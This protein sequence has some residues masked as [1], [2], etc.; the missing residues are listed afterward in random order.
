MNYS[1]KGYCKN[2]KNEFEKEHPSKRYCSD[3]CYFLA[4]KNRN[5]IIARFDIFNRDNFTCFYCG[6]NPQEHKIS[7]DVDHIIP[8]S[9][10]GNNSIDNLVTS[11]HECNSC[12]NDKMLS[13]DKLEKF[14]GIISERNNLH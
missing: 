9:K 12:K 2:C 7:L 13:D 4:Q 10:G 1:A 8:L 3:E 6:K 11:C 5:V 14:L